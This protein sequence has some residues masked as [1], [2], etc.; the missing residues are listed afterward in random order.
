MQNI[1]RVFLGSEFC[2]FRN[3]EN[4]RNSAAF[5]K[6]SFFFGLKIRTYNGKFYYWFI[7]YCFMLFIAGKLIEILLK[8]DDKVKILSSIDF[9]QTKSSNFS[10]NSQYLSTRGIAATK[11]NIF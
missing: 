3:F 6:I 5:S 7:F 9:K 10:R 4:I 1:F 8:I 11:I 2:V